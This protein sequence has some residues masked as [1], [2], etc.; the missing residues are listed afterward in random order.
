[1]FLNLSRLIVK[2]IGCSS[3]LISIGHPVI[4][5]LGHSSSFCDRIKESNVTTTL[6]NSTNICLFLRKKNLPET[7]KV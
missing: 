7:Q 1:M 6:L 5:N 2:L 3:F 4:F